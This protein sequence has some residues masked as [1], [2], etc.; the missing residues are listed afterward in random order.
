MFVEKKRKKRSVVYQSKSKL[1]PIEYYSC[2]VGEI[3]TVQFLF[4]IQQ[5]GYDILTSHLGHGS[6]SAVTYLQ[7]GCKC[8]FFID[9][10]R[11]PTG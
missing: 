5:V 6:A 4:F 9:L 10:G 7:I 3:T 11:G 8:L 1:I 2:V